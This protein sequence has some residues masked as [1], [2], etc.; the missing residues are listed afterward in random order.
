MINMSLREAQLFRM[1]SGFFGRDQVIMRMSVLAICGGELPDPLPDSVLAQL[2]RGGAFNLDQWAK[3]NTCLF[4]IVDQN[5]MPRMV[6][7]FFA[8]FESSVD[9]IEEE[10]QRLLPPLFSRR[11]IP[12]VTISDQ[13]FGDLVDPTSSLDFC[14]FLEA[15]FTEARTFDA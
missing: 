1:L 7:E 4:T 3:K 5:D 12:Y 8:G 13:E 15:K 2:G 10:H 6:I 9:P 11:Q 14:T